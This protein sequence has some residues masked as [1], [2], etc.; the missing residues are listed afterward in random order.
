MICTA[1]RICWSEGANGSPC[2]SPTM[3]L[4][5]SPMPSTTRPGAT[6]LS[7][8]AVCPSTT[9]VRVWTGKT[10]EPTWSRS[11][12]PAIVAMSVIAS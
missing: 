6:W 4:L 2:Q 1:S 7:V 12:A 9:G 10:A 5:E 11:V 3:T 8:A